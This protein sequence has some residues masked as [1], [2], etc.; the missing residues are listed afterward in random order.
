MFSYSS[1]GNFAPFYEV[2]V[3][4]YIDGRSRA[5]WLI[6]LLVIVF[7]YNILICSKAF[8]DVIVSKLIGKS[9]YIWEKTEHNGYISYM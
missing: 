6:P 2:G 1:I 8:L 3:G 4:A 5:C 9:R 7:F